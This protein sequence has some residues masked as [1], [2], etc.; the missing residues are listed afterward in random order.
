MLGPRNN[1]TTALAIATEYRDAVVVNALCNCRS[2]ESL[3][4]YA[5]KPSS[6]S[7]LNVH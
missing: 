2:A 3:V 1:T 6:L 5:V 7:D 4:Q